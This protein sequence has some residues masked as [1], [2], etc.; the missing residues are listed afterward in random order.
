MNIF[1]LII[2]FIQGTVTPG[3]ETGLYK[4]KILSVLS[5]LKYREITAYT[6][7][8]LAVVFSPISFLQLR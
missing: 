8:V 5:S 7:I 2:V 1:I 4:I 3:Y 6:D